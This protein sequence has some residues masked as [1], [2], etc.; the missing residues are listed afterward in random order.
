D[1][2]VV[3]ESESV[4][5]P[6]GYLSVGTINGGT[7]TV[8]E[9]ASLAVNGLGDFNIGDIGTGPSSLFIEGGDISVGAFWLGR[10]V[11]TSGVVIQTG[12]NFIDREGGADNRIGGSTPEANGSY[13]GWTIT[14]GTLQAGANLQIGAYGTG[15]MTVDG[16]QVL[17]TGGFVAVGRYR[18]EGFQSRGVLDIRSGSFT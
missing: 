18:G 17:G 2:S 10:N 11:G 3:L 12:G 8:R 7:M 15:L 6:N 14:G 9:G 5:A 1:G 13:G 16:G 4:A